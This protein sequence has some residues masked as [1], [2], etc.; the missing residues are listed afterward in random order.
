VLLLN[1][2]KINYRIHTDAIKQNLVPKALTKQQTA[3]IYATEA[4]VLNMALFGKTAK[5]WREQNWCFLSIF[6][7]II[8][9][10]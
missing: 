3:F 6:A 10:D 7:V 2:S 4:D 5:Q 1:L 9:N 8:Q